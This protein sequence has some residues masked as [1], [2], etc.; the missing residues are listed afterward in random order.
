MLVRIYFALA[1]A[2]PIAISRC[3]L[4]GLGQTASLQ[5][6]EEVRRGALELAQMLVQIFHHLDELLGGR[7]R[8]FRLG[9]LTLLGLLHGRVH[10]AAID[11]HVELAG[12][13]N[14]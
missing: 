1:G 11:P 13:G 9:S 14:I 3:H 10:G 7:N 6:Q 5:R 8:I 12:G 4:C 2:A